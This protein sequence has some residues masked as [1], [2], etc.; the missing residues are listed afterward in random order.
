MIG[1]EKHSL[2]LTADIVHLTY[3]FGGSC[4]PTIFDR[5]HH[6]LPNSKLEDS[7]MLCRIDQDVSN[8]LWLLDVAFD[9][10]RC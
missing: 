9:P 3:E 6:F 2:L 8:I 10:K 4:S 5:I 7:Q 1:A